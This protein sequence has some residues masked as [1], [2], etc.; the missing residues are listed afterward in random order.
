MESVWAAFCVALERRIG[1]ENVAIW[2]TR[3]VK[4]GSVEP[5]RV[6]LCAENRIT[7]EWVHQA[8]L[9][10]IRIAW[11]EV[12]GG[13]VEVRLSFDGELPEHGA[14][15]PPPRAGRGASGLRREFTFENFVVGTGNELA[16][17]LASAVADAPGVAYN[18]LFLHGGNGHGKT[19]LMHAIGNRLEQHR[20]GAVEYWPAQ[21][22]F[23]AMVEA[24]QE[25][26]IFDFCKRFSSEID[27]LLLDNMQF[28]AR[29]DRTQEIVCPLFEG[30]VRS[31]TQI[32]LCADRPPKEIGTLALRLRSR[33]R[34]VAIAE[35]CAPDIETIVAILARKAEHL[36]TSTPA[37]VLRAS[38]QRTSSVP[39]AWGARNGWAARQAL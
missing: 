28:I 12:Q 20:G 21:Q 1:H 37:D 34:Q 24:F 6:R 18:P 11:E 35:V 5:G 16:H 29:G 39:E 10:D 8:F 7:S 15:H 23:D 19:H 33:F 26:N 36:G 13:P 3:A 14:V 17:G 31:G 32:I 2:F 9:R 38:A 30:M 4:L 27:V 25:R 22:F